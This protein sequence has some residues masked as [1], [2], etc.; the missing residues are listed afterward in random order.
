MVNNS[1]QYDISRDKQGR[2]NLPSRPNQQ[3]AKTASPAS[4]VEARPWRQWHSAARPVQ[5][6]PLEVAV[7]KKPQWGRWIYF[8]IILGLLAAMLNFGFQ[9]IFWFQADGIIS[10]KQYTVSATDTVSIQDILVSPSDQVE[11][12][13][14]LAKL[15][16]PALIQSLAKNEAEIAR[17]QSD[18]AQDSVRNDGSIS[19]LH[20]ELTSL[21]AEKDFLESQYY[22]ETLQIEALTEL[23]HAGAS[24]RG[25]LNTLQNQHNKTWSDYVRVKAAMESAR[26]QISSLRNNKKEAAE[27]V[28]SD[29]LAALKS[30]HGSIQDQ[31]SSLDLRAP[32]SGTVARV[33][34]A[35]GDVLRA[36]ETAVEM[37]DKNKLSAYMYFPPAAEGRVSKGM[38]FEA[39]K[40]DGST[41]KLLVD[42]VYPSTE[43]VPAQFR[44]QY[45]LDSA[46]VMVEASL[47]DGQSFELGITSGTPIAAR[48]PRWSLPFS[49]DVFGGGAKVAATSP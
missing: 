5:S 30:L 33:P 47:L 32:I 14:L 41:I 25:N 19:Q 23:V 21:Q 38:V 18:L 31:L 10:G 4:S 17:I 28:L 26:S 11:E 27:P 43:S 35:K 20:A 16:S 22:Q 24:Q 1:S 34:V 46:A 49:A 8:V 12:G 40:A 39:A 6:P 45:D 7:A 44:D 13:Q 9:Q 29:R 15:S 37:V 2:G 36:G 42:K 3:L 48:I